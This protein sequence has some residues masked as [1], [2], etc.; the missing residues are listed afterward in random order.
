MHLGTIAQ[1]QHQMQV[2]AQ[3]LRNIFDRPFVAEPDSVCLA[4]FGDP[5]CASHLDLEL[6][7][8]ERLDAGSLDAVRSSGGESGHPNVPESL[9]GLDDV[10][11]ITEQTETTTVDGG[12]DVDGAPKLG[13]DKEYQY[14]YKFPP[15]DD[16]YDGQANIAPV[17]HFSRQAF[18]DGGVID[19]VP[20]FIT[21]GR[22][23]DQL[24][25]KLERTVGSARHYHQLGI[26]DETPGPDTEE[27]SDS[28]PSEEPVNALW[29][30]LAETNFEVR[31]TINEVAKL[32]MLPDSTM[33][34]H[35]RVV[36]TLPHDTKIAFDPFM[37]AV[38]GMLPVA[39]FSTAGGQLPPMEGD[40]K[41]TPSS[42]DAARRARMNETQG[43]ILRMMPLCREIHFDVDTESFWDAGIQRHTTDR[44]ECAARRVVTEF[45][46]HGLGITFAYVP[47]PGPKVFRICYDPSIVG[48]T[49]ALA[50]FPSDPRERW[51]VRLSYRAAVSC[52]F[53]GR[54]ECM[55]NIL[56][57]EFMHI[58]GFRHWN[59]GFDVNEMQVPS[60]HLPGTADGDWESVMYTSVHDRLWFNREDYRAIQKVYKA[61]SGDKMGDCLIVDVDPYI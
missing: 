46:K 45:G 61:P 43:M 37:A 51:Q 14:M 50:F 8:G 7:R 5:T 60:V 29:K 17:I 10:P 13:C 38:G 41:G 27:A 19:I 52:A 54:L 24:P 22:D 30:H 21:V 48:D 36:I 56:A 40:W 58:L 25:N 4:E 39:H 3:V 16:P 23:R 59:A 42:S 9:I 32:D 47:G 49:L 53:G 31:E 6:H 11:E 28:Q 26:S 35:P 15:R 1:V 18:R 33:S 20:D 57:H 2:M 55:H 34:S 44:I 12:D